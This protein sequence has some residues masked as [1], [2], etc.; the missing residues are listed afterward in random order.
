MFSMSDAADE[1]M[2]IAAPPISISAAKA[3]FAESAGKAHFERLKP[4]L[5][6]QTHP[7]GTLVCIN[8]VDGNYVI[9]S[10]DLDVIDMFRARFGGSAIGWIEELVD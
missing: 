9:G 4:H 8:V 7:P 1:N 2:S 6:L 3:D 10:S 5:R